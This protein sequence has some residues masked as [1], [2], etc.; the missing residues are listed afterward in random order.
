[1]SKK[2]FIELADV[3]R[4]NKPQASDNPSMCDPR[5][6]SAALWQWERM[7]N[8][9]ADFCKSQNSMF[10]RDRWLAYIN[11]ECGPNGGAVTGGIHKG[12]IRSL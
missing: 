12:R 5:E 7:R 10:K 4:N 2:H 1:M 8:A 11:G 9:L 6:F 3:V